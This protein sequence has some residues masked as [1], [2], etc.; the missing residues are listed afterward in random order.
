MEGDNFCEL[1]WSAELDLTRTTLQTK[2]VYQGSFQAAAEK[3]LHIVPMLVVP[4]ELWA[5]MFQGSVAN[6]LSYQKKSIKS[7]AWF[8]TK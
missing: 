1:L 5:L 6:R 4:A 3:I 8:L 2:K 7:I